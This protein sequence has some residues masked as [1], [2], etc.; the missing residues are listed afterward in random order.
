[1]IFHTLGQ[2]N[3]PAIFIRIHAWSGVLIL[4]SL[5]DLSFFALTG[6][7]K[8]WENKVVDSKLLVEQWPNFVGIT[9]IA[10]HNRECRFQDGSLRSREINLYS[11]RQYEYY[12]FIC[13]NYQFQ[14]E[15][16]VKY[17]L[18]AKLARSVDF[19]SFHHLT[20]QDWIFWCNQYSRSCIF[21][22]WI[23]KFSN[24]D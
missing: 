24:N 23:L 22:F 17:R 6:Y 20:I 15:S 2:E 18:H 16:C 3:N 1:M 19:F 4:F 12:E 8:K 9:V 21:F 11:F 14:N 13:D 7:R 10:M 5:V